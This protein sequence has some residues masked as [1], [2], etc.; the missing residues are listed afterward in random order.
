MQNFVDEH[1]GIDFDE[2]LP[3][4]RVM[5]RRMG[6]R[7]RSRR[8]RRRRKNLLICLQDELNEFWK[9]SFPEEDVPQRP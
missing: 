2:N 6:K 7:S 1:M 5:R 3:S 8:R 4:H 9:I